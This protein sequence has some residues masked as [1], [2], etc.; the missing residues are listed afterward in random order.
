MVQIK[1]PV[2][3]L[4]DAKYYLGIAWNDEI[5]WNDLSK[6]VE[7]RCGFPPTCADLEDFL[8]DSYFKDRNSGCSSTW[9]KARSASGHLQVRWNIADDNTVSIT[10]GDLTITNRRGVFKGIRSHFKKF[11]CSSLSEK[12]R[13]GKSFSCYSKDRA[14]SHFLRTGD[15]LRFTDWR[16]S[17]T[18]PD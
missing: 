7:Q 15:Y 10:I 8:S 18:K 1:Y 5:A 16:G 4:G 13:Q 17:F 3:D 6:I 14:S 12:P 2:T 11:A 9:S